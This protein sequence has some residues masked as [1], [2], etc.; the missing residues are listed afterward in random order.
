MD[1]TLTP[2]T[3][4]GRFSYSRIAPFS[5]AVPE[6]SLIVADSSQ[7]IAKY[8][9]RFQAAIKPMMI[10]SAKNTVAPAKECG[11]FLRRCRLMTNSGRGFTLVELLVVIAIIG[12]LVSL[13]LPAV[14][15][16]R[17][18]SRRTKCLNH[19]RQLELAVMNF[20]SA[21]G[22]D[23]PDALHN[24]PPTPPGKTKA[25]TSPL[26]MHIAT[27][28]YTENKALREKYTAVASTLDFFEVAIY[29]CPSDPSKALVEN[30]PTT[31]SYLSNG[32]LFSD[33]PN[34][35]KVTDGTSNTIAFA[36]SYART[37]LSGNATVTVYSTRSGKGA[38]TFAHVCNGETEFCFDV[39]IGPPGGGSAATFGRSNRPEMS[40]PGNWQP[41]FNAA[42]N[43]AL[44]DV[45]DPPI[46][47]SPDPEQ[48]DIRLLQSIHP[49]VI[50]MVML[51]NSVRSVSDSIDPIVF[52]SY[53]TPAGGESVRFLE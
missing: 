4:A 25:E 20:S 29:N 9:S 28:P 38:A 18:A 40:T 33:E 2:V 6:S 12:V 23:L 45:I 8:A 11:H 52:W 7:W 41:D 19:M 10:I 48:S 17:E 1:E 43:N 5:R 42:A 44:D 32:T 51:D 53:V 34:F 30:R 47:S 21:M 13:L 35:R 3:E 14:Q 26:S 50:N 37:E 27:M 39:R 22:E 24:Y 46:E 15:A 31:T 36:E 49:G 16:A